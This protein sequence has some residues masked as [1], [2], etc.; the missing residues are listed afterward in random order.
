[1]LWSSF[2]IS[3]AKNLGPEWSGGFFLA[4]EEGFIG[5]L[6]ACAIIG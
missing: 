5:F 3:R 1:M 6:G 2:V 4:E